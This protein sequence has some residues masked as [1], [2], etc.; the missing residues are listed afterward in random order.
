VPSKHVPY[1]KPGKE[2]KDLINTSAA[3]DVETVLTESDSTPV[4]S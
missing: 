1:F 4:A 3:D 2:L